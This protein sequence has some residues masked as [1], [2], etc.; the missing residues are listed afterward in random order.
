MEWSATSEDGK[1]IITGI[2]APGVDHVSGTIDCMPCEGT[3]CYMPESFDF[4]IRIDGKQNSGA[5][6][7]PLG[8]L[9]LEALLW[10]LAMIFTPCVFP[11][12][13][14]TVSYFLRQNDDRRKAVGKA[15]FYGF[16]IILIYTLPVLAG[17]LISRFAGAEVVSAGAL[18]ALSTHWLP[19]ILFF[20][21]FLLFSLSFFGL[22]EFRLP[23]KWVNAADKKSDGGGLAPLFF[24]ALTLVLLSFSCTGPIVGTVLIRSLSGDYFAPVLAILVFSAAFALPFVLF[25]L[26]PNLLSSLPKSGGWLETFKVSLGFI[27][28]ALSLKFLSIADQAYH[29]NLLPRKLYLAIWVVIFLLLALY[30]IGVFSREKPKWTAARG[31]WLAVVCAFIVYLCSGFAGAP[32]KAL[33]G[34]LPPQQGEFSPAEPEA[35]VDDAR[36]ELA[37]KEAG[38]QG[39]KVLVYVSGYA[40]VNCREMEARVLSSPRVK[41]VLDRDYLILKIYVDDKA[42][43]EH[44]AARTAI[45]RFGVNSQP[46]F[47]VLDA[48][49][50]I[51]RGPYSYN[52]SVN[53]FLD[54][55]EPL[56]HL[57]E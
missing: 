33:S 21:I 23:S 18:N 9:L 38:A 39:K 10:G 50:E 2:P 51:V 24:M 56:D 55:L 11:M 47:L 36:I 46:N 29:W 3:Q 48:D 44:V 22:F 30:L 25:A 31:V 19:N 49:G 4:D 7:L 1:I 16:F 41:E 20:V 52:L 43:R 54:F 40:C 57:A 34:Y 17:I 27:E 13:P 15:F 28:L 42:D 45:K 6:S 53:G 8:A 26:F 37:L 5:A 14:M 35:P 32:L 12:V